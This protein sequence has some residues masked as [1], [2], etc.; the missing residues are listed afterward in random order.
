MTTEDTTTAHES[1][2]EV[3]TILTTLDC[4]GCGTPDMRPDYSRSRI[5]D[6]E[7]GMNIVHVCK[8]CKKTASTPQSYPIVT[9]R[10]IE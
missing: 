7:G 9:Y 8:V 10:R 1:I 6:D 4:D 2:Y 3:K 5:T